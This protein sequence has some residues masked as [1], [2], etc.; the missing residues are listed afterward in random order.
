M[1]LHATVGED[2]NIDGVKVGR[3]VGAKETSSD[4]NDD[5]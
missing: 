4:G 5:G 2:D 3:D 1:R